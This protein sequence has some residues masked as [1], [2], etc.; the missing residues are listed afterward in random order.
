M[1]SS[2]Y[3]AYEVTDKYTAS[4]ASITL[5]R[6]T[7]GTKIVSGSREVATFSCDNVIAVRELD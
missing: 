7:K 1:E 5:E 3:L 4:S 6:A 2:I